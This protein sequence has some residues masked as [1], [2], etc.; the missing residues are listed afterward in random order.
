V[1]VLAAAITLMTLDPNDHKD[2]I[3]EKVLEKTGRSLALNGDISVT[4]Y[5]W[6]G[7]EAHQLDVGNAA[8]FGEA[9]FLHV[10]Y[11]KLRIKLMPMFKEHYEVDTVSVHGAVINLARNEEGAN[12]WDD[13][14]SQEKND[15]QVFP[16]A[17]VVLGGVDIEKA[18]LN[19]TDASTDTQYEIREMDIKTDALTYGE[20]IKLSL[21]FNMLANKPALSGDL[22]LDGTI[23]YDTDNQLYTLNPLTVLANIEGENIP[24]GGTRATLSA[25]IDVDLNEDTARIQDLKLAVLDMQVLV[26]L[27]ASHIQEPSPSLQ[28][29]VE[30]EGADLALLFKVAEIEP[31][32]TQISEVSDRSFTA[33]TS[34]DA[35]LERGDIN[36]SELVLA[37][38]GADVKGK[39]KAL[40][41]FS[42]T[43]G[44][45]GQLK[46]AGPDLPTLL[47]VFGQ[48]QG[49]SESTL[50]QYGAT[51]D[52]SK[53]KN[54]MI[55]AS[56][57]ADLKTGDVDVSK[58]A[59]Q[60]LG[61]T[62]KGNVKARNIGSNTPGYKGQLK[63]N[64]PDL[65]TL[66]QLFGQLQG[67]NDSVLSEYG[68]KFAGIKHKAFKI[69]TD[70][71]ADMESGDIDLPK[72]DI[73]TL[74]IKVQ[75]DLKASNMSAESG[76]INGKLD[77]NGNDLAPLLIAI[78]QQLLSE[79]LKS[80]R[81][82]AGISGDTNNLNL[83]SM[84]LRASV[85]GKQVGEKPVAIS[86]KAD[87]NVNLEKQT[88]SMAGLSIKGLGLD[89]S[90]NIKATNIDL[91]P[92]YSGQLNV[93]P[94]NLRALMTKLGQD[95]P[96]TV[97]KKVF[98]KLGFE[99][100]FVKSSSNFEVKNLNMILDQTSLSGEF[101]M[102]G[103]ENPAIKFILDIDRIN[104]DQYLSPSE[105]GE[106]NRPITLE[107]AA[108]KL[109]IGIL[110][111]LNVDGSLAIGKLT[112]SKVKLTNVNLKL[113]GKDGKIVLAPVAANLYQG[114]Y[115]GKISINAN[116][117]IPKLVVNSAIKGVQIEPL[118]MDT[119]GSADLVGRSDISIAVV[120]RGKNTDTF[121][122]TLSGQV[123]LK[124]SNGILRGVDVPSALEQVELM[125]ENKRFG[126]VN[127]EGDTSFDSLTATLPINAGIVNNQDLL[128]TAPGFKVTG[129]GVFARLVDMSWKYDLKV[130]VD[131]R[132]LSQGEKT[133]NLG[134][135]TIPIKCRG[136][137]VGSNCKPD[138]MNLAGRAVKKM[139]FDE[140][141]LSGQGQGQTTPADATSG[142]QNVDPSKEMLNKAL[143]S[144]FN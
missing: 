26:N 19:W 29:K 1:A 59:M 96:E 88:M 66:L 63:A 120:A 114:S 109:P 51:V 3:S 112:L 107:T 67:D 106:D 53:H 104:V 70:F 2:W 12:N 31:L 64:G 78:D 21:D 89:V 121:K 143:K 48:F 128:L 13:L 71:D 8:G 74:G 103:L 41:I 18:S 7:L 94:F 105:E 84:I 55:D 116:G 20:P 42:E 50:S 136:K 62:V 111:A 117:K 52:R 140:L 79:S 37:M 93:V 80:I 124:V 16:F 14:M 133:Y 28:A 125:I 46:A 142:D 131:E 95:L 99:T 47:Q 39:V 40:N 4:L 25:A 126:K 141:N 113:K 134:D 27:E 56:F 86:L 30:I 17:A 60:M 34:L 118:L 130:A 68:Q 101:S 58:L 122:Q 65:P 35:D 36:V 83:K 76:K 139:I 10:D 45:K 102:L 97:D 61:A 115:S 22:K 24:G 15:T 32:A 127:I 11:L 110:Q 108:I 9:S 90:G 137:I 69:E 72:F 54:F 6:L 119:T 5:P 138:T 38:L 135:Y 77:I 85:V 87:T 123:E 73:N 100:Q 98:R 57:D 91:E 49:G 43:P 144:I 129:K 23:A 81:F 75:G 82:N 92:A 132:S 33:H 44:Y